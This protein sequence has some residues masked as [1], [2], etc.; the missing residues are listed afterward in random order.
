MSNKK[1]VILI[2][3]DSVGAGEMPDSEEFGDKGA[4]TIGNIAQSI[5]G[6]NLPNLQKMGLGN[7]LYIKGV[8]PNPDSLASYGKMMEAS[9]NKDTMT[10]HWEIMGLITKQHFPVFPDGFPEEILEDFFKATGVHKILGNKAASGT[11]IIQELGEEH[12][13]TGFPIVYTSGD[14][15]FQIAAHEH[16][17]YVDELYKMCEATRKVCDKYNIGRVIARPFIGKNGNFKRTFRRKD[18]PMKPPYETVLDILKAKGFPVIGIGKIGDIFAE[19]GLTK[20]IHTKNNKEG[21]KTLINELSITENGLIFINLVDFDML[22]GHRRDIKGYANALEIFD[23]EFSLLL[24]HLEHNDILII[25]ADHGCDPTHHGTDHTREHV[26]LLVYSK[27][28][29]PVNLGIRRSFSDIGVSIL[30]LFEIE[31]KFPGKSFF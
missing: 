8:A 19:Q 4:N 9:K 12:I 23:N 25:T 14:S 3:L 26:P 5:G 13:K 28:M 1:R 15:V 2:V 21:I 17:I 27:L 30:E 31:H 20:I 10:G 6:L 22:Y 29:H 7:I 18:F 11:V 16:I 24:Q